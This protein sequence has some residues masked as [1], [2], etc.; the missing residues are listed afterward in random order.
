[1]EMN[2]L[3]DSLTDPVLKVMFLVIKKC[4][5]FNLLV[6]ITKH[7]VTI[8]YK[9]ATFHSHNHRFLLKIGGDYNALKI[10]TWCSIYVIVYTT[11][12]QL[13]DIN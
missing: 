2:I 4:N 8:I 9:S 5:I 1:M 12:L 13:A 7:F 3:F 11:N 6:S 10:E